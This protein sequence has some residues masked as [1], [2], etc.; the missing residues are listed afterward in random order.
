MKTSFRTVPD[1]NVIIAAQS[2]AVASPNKE[3]FERW[4]NDEFELLFS[5]DTLREYIEK[6]TERN[7]PRPI[8]VQ[9]VISIL[10]LGSHIP[11][12]FSILLNILPIRM[13][14]PFCCVLKMVTPPTLL[15]T[16]L[17]FWD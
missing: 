9:L 8:I 15:V 5:D 13:T 14:Y 10:E 11:I 16:I 1:T 6:L 7:V 4:K 17:I 3:Y 2:P 12:S